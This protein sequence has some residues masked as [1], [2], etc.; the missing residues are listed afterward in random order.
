MSHTKNESPSRLGAAAPPT[1]Q[2]LPSPTL[3]LPNPLNTGGQ[4]VPTSGQ[5]DSLLQGM[6]RD[7]TSTP[8]DPFA[9]ITMRRPLFGGNI[10]QVPMELTAPYVPPGASFCSDLEQRQ[11]GQAPNEALVNQL[12][13]IVDSHLSS[14]MAAMEKTLKKEIC[15]TVEADMAQNLNV[16]MERS[17]KNH[18]EPITSELKNVTQLL[19]ASHINPSQQTEGQ[20]VSRQMHDDQQAPSVAQ[21][22][23]NQQSYSSQDVRRRDHK[24][25]QAAMNST[26]PQRT[27][28]MPDSTASHPPQGGYPYNTSS[29]P[30]TAPYSQGAN[31]YTPQ[32]RAGP[33]N[34]DGFRSFPPPPYP[35][36]PM[37]FYHQPGLTPYGYAYS[38]NMYEFQNQAW[39]NQMWQAQPQ[40]QWNHP[41]MES[42][43]R[44]P[45][46]TTSR[47]PRP[48]SEA[49]S[50][51]YGGEER[52]ERPETRRT[53]RD[54]MG[55]RNRENNRELPRYLPKM[56]TFEGKATTWTSFINMFE[57]RATHLHWNDEEKLEKIILCLSGKAIDFYIKVRD[58]GK[59]GTYADF[60]QQME[61][62][63][64]V[65]E[66]AS[67]LRSKFNSM[68]Q[69]A[70]EKEEDW[71]ERVMT[72]G[73]E[74][75]KG[76]TQEFIEGEIVRRYCSGSLDKEAAEHVLNSSPATFEEAQKMLKKYREN[77]KAIHG[78]NSKKVRMISMDHDRDRSRSPYRSRRGR[79]PRRSNKMVRTLSTDKDSRD[80]SNS[81]SR[82]RRNSSPRRSSPVQNINSSHEELIKRISEVIDKKI[83]KRLNRSK[84]PRRDR[85][86]FVCKSKDHLAPDCPDKVDGAC[87]ICKDTGHR[88]LDCPQFDSENENRSTQ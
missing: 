35:N 51:V 19:A 18:L 26:S 13:N 33:I 21:A 77:R 30:N 22:T 53:D 1:G 7:L 85:A 4:Y 37:Q 48:P 84:S 58:Q 23:R 31:Y 80:K 42:A 45:V 81:P 3:G 36:I 76:L 34:M 69:Y 70:D 20:D 39:I 28:Q 65:Q 59:C 41:S 50:F 27:S 68:K 64:Y 56:P 55:R 15:S 40:Q 83:E 6:N 78:Y 88:Y 14:R 63:F 73:Y 43:R 79:S 57:M 54:N 75:F 61:S 38:P 17:I 66:E 5:W 60:K 87:Y 44:F 82:N 16:T 67:T 11:L 49:E 71:S 46:D 25:D 72:V 86:C 2:G 10:E 47:M 62:R 24:S 29:Y 9:H 74:A 12:V 8:Y 32:Q 52:S